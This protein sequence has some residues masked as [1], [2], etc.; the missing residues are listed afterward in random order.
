MP[1]PVKAVMF[2]DLFFS[3]FIQVR[4]HDIFWGGGLFGAMQSTAFTPKEM[5]VVVSL[6]MRVGTERSYKCPC[7]NDQLMV[8]CNDSSILTWN[9]Q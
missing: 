4:M 9:V 8:G 6:N 5:V 3:P 2:G 7:R 1:G